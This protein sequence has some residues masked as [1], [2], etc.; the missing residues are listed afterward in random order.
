M[1]FNLFRKHGSEGGK[2]NG[3]E[4]TPAE[5]ALIGDCS[6]LEFPYQEIA[7]RLDEAGLG[8]DRRDLVEGKIRDKRMESV[9]GSG[10]R[11]AV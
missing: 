2:Q 4:F 10:E 3:F 1:G 11:K 7:G 5:L 6:S 9:L 8:D